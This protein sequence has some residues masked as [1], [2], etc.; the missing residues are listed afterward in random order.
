MPDQTI[1]GDDVQRHH[2]HA[3]TH[4][5]RLPL[6]GGFGDVG[7]QPGG[8][9]GVTAPAHHFGHDAGVPR[10]ARGGERPGHES[11]KHGRQIEL[12]PQQPA[13]QTQITAGLAQ[14]AGQGR[15]R[16]DDRKQDVPL[17]AQNHQRRG[18]HVDIEM[19]VHDGHHHQ[20]EQQIGG[21]GGEK[22]R[23]RLRHGRPARTQTDPDAHRHPD[24]RRN[25]HQHEHLERGERAQQHHMTDLQPAEISRQHQKQRHDQAESEQHHADDKHPVAPHGRRALRRFVQRHRGQQAHAHLPQHGGQ[26]GQALGEAGAAQKVEHHR[27]RRVHA[28]GVVQTELVGPG[29]DGAKQQKVVRQNHQG[30]RQ[31]RPTDGA[32]ILGRDCRGDIGADTRHRH[33]LPRH[34]ERLG[35]D[36]EEPAARHGH[37]RVPQ[38][39]RGGVGELKLPEA[40]PGVEAVKRGGLGEVAR[41]GLERL[42]QA[43][44]HVPRLRREHRKNHRELQ[45]QHA[46]RKQGDEAGH[47]DRQI[48]QNRHRLQHVEQRHHD[49]FG[50]A[51]VGRDPGVDQGEHGT[52]G[53]R[54]QHAQHGVER[55]LGQ[56]RGFERQRHGLAQMEWHRHLPTG[57]A[58]DE[59]HADDQRQ[60]DQIAAVG[61]RQRQWTEIEGHGSGR[62]IE[63]A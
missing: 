47:G 19:P 46:A 38:Q 42:V 7:A 53:Q 27:A 49:F 28:D 52:G 43:E 45:P 18:E 63:A 10:A 41:H 34:G 24:Q 61:Q 57:V 31:N 60:R 4:L 44:S 39:A 21:E 32:Q 1:D 8:D 55:V 12:A 14:V 16:A 58:D 59:Q 54:G 40:L 25:R 11:R 33:L 56:I 62:T 3:K 22:L 48:A 26:P 6:L 51:I 2:A 37:H 20:R 13:A 9:Q 23:H 15:G 36:D 29:D 30:H 5:Q 35:S 17:A 50:V